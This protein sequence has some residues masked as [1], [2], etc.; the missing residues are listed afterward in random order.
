VDRRR[1]HQRYT[2]QR[3]ADRASRPLNE[4][5]HFSTPVENVS[6]RVCR[7]NCGDMCE[8]AAIAENVFR[9][10]D[11]IAPLRATQFLNHNFGGV[12]RIPVE[13]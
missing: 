11:Q 8:L 5:Q 12:S 7:K 4:H 6:Q 3:A 13:P 1:T 10:M 9:F 2:H